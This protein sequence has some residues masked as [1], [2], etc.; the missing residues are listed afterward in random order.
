MHKKELTEFEVSP[1]GGVKILGQFEG[2][3]NL[4]S[5]SARRIQIRFGEEEAERDFIGEAAAGRI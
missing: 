1:K 4:M 2:I 3:E 5:G